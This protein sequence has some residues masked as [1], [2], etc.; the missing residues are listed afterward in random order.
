MT[1]LPTIRFT[2][3]DR[4]VVLVHGVAPPSDED[5]AAYLEEAWSLDAVVPG[6]RTLVLTEGGSPNALQRRSLTTRVR[7]Y[8]ASS[9]AVV[10]PARTVR[11]IVTAFSWFF[12]E[13]KFFSPDKLAGAFAYLDL[14]GE[15]QDIAIDA[16]LGL[17][18]DAS[19]FDWKRE[20]RGVKTAAR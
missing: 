2:R 3:L 19:G 5:W 13:I 18:D 7:R 15:Q 14:N 20:F 6:L 10:S 12:P 4:V 9:S 8:G 1:H 16:A 17:L 11:L